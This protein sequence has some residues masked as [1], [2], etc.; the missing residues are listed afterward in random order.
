MA[1]TNDLAHEAFMD[2]LAKTAYEAYCDHAEWKNFEGKPIPQWDDLDESTGVQDK[3]RTSVQA[4]LDAARVIEP[5]TPAAVLHRYIQENYRKAPHGF[6]MFLDSVCPED[7]E[8]GPWVT[9]GIHPV[10]VDGETLLLH[11][12]DAR[13]SQAETAQVVMSPDATRES[14]AWRKAID[15]VLQ[16]IKEPFSGRTSPERSLAITKL[17]EGIMWLGMDLKAQRD[18]GIH[19]EPSPYADSYNPESDAPIAPTADG[20]KL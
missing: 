9:V 11:I 3:W 17:K 13:V 10:D 1:D 14:R 18:E 2:H 7:A 4:V 5:K 8:S 16:R 12:D 15:S 6:R 20:L 19:D